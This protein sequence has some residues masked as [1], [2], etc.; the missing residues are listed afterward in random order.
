MADKPLGLVT[1]ATGNLAHA[2]AQVPGD[3]Y[4]T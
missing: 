3:S 2:L 4:A 1:G